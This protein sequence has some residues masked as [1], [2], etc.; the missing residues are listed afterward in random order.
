MRGCQLVEEKEKR[1]RVHRGNR[2]EGQKTKD[3][4]GLGRLREYV[5]GVG[6]ALWPA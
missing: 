3:F 5:E 6:S 4:R 2:D 1:P